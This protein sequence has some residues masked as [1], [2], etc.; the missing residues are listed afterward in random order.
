MRISD[1]S[2]DVCSS[3]LVLH[4]LARHA[5]LLHQLD[6]LKRHIDTGH[7]HQPGRKHQQEDD[8]EMAG[9]G[10]RPADILRA[11]RGDLARIARQHP[12][13]DDSDEEALEQRLAKSSAEH[14]SELQSLMR[15]SYAVF[16]MKKTTT[17]TS[18][19]S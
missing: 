2:S 3:D 1:W 11:K 16:C 4:F 17:I 7:H 19:F 12:P 15:T 8:G 6:D 10:N 13:A 14:T 9:M 5:Q 18:I